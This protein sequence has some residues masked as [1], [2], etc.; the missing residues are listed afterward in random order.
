MIFIQIYCSEHENQYLYQH[1]SMHKRKS[2]QFLE[3]YSHYCS[4]IYLGLHTCS[5]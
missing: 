3:Q 4:S 2:I 1:E 5:L